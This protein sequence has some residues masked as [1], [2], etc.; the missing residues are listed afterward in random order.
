M[1]DM[2]APVPGEPSHIAQTRAHG[3]D[4]VDVK[5]CLATT[6]PCEVVAEQLSWASRLALQLQALGIVELVVV[7]DASRTWVDSALLKEVAFLQPAGLADG[8][9]SGS[10]GH[11]SV[12]K[13]ELAQ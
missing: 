7:G 8:H 9:S 4:S 10:R 6:L 3:E 13:K 1:V 12:G 11:G 2:V 5:P